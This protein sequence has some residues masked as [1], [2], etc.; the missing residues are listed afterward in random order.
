MRKLSLV[1]I[2]FIATAAFAQNGN[3]RKDPTWWDK[4]QFILNNGPTADPGPTSSVAA[5]T[6]VDVSNECGPQSE[7]YITLNPANTRNLAGGSNEIFRLPM[8]G[9]F[10]TDGGKSWGGVDAPL[11]P[12]IGANG[13]DFGSDPTLAFDSRGN[14]FYGYI[15]V[16]FSRG[17]GFGSINGTQ[18]A[19][20]KSTDGGKTY[21]TATFFEFQGGENHFNDKPMIT[22]DAN[23][24]SPFRDNVYIAWDAASGG[25]AT[26]G[27][28]RVAT[29]NDRGATFTATRADDPHGPGRG[30]GAIPFVGTSGELYVAWNDY[31]SNTIAFNRSFDSGATWDTQTV[32]ASKVIP[33]DIRIPAE[34]FRGALVY[35]TCD[36]D[37]SG[38]AHRGRLVCSWMDLAGNG[39]T[40]IFTSFSDD[41]GTT[42]SLP[43]TATDALAFAVDRFYPWIS[44]DPTNGVVN[45]S[46][47]DT[48]ND[49]TGF[50]FMT[51]TYLS[52][53]SNGGASFG[54]N[55]RVSTESS[56]E[57]DCNGLFPCPSIN[58]GNQQGDYEGLVAY[59]G[60]AHPIWTD[61]RRNQEPAPGCMTRGLMEEVFTASVK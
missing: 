31:G 48:R 59:G 21:P 39:T 20:A 22:A 8:R 10:S 40:D 52:R 35:P 15:V 1:V 3:T 44:I 5:A 49:T 34:S 33:F 55:V 57:H 19:V 18:M 7:T 23:P 13:F 9:Y 28:I 41:K 53:S 24:A 26:S 54:A 61:S 14:L 36:V 51:D 4:Y 37:R 42:W 60:V 50:R 47:Y 27:G 12:A 16:F 46:F 17:Q 45:I 6:N 29:S 43:R 58:Y 56:N 32:I 11:P 2:C 25:S 30:I 38:S